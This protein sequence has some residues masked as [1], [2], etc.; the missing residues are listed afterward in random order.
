MSGLDGFAGLSVPTADQIPIGG[1]SHNAVGDV[2]L[3]EKQ[4]AVALSV[5]GITEGFIVE[6]GKLGG[7]ALIESCC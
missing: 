4:V 2:A 3:P 6:P 1:R 5:L 7:M